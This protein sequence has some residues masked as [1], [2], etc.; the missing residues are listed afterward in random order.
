MKLTFE[1]KGF[2]NNILQHVYNK[3]NWISEVY[4]TNKMDGKDME[5]LIRVL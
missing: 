3:L 2:N 5:G 1:S 4:V